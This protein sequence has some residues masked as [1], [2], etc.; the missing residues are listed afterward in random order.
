MSEPVEITV[1]FTAEDLAI[2]TRHVGRRKPKRLNAFA[3]LIVFL[4][5]ALSVGVISSPLKNLQSLLQPRSLYILAAIALVAVLYYVVRQ[6]VRRQKYGFFAKR[7]FRNRINESA[8]LRDPKSIRFSDAGVRYAD[9]L[10]TTEIV[11]EAYTEI[12]ETDDYLY[13]YTSEQSAQIFPK[14]AF[15]EHGLEM[16]RI[17]L[18]SYLPPDRNL[19]LLA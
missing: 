15:S 4:V 3:P 9:R 2:T 11:W 10:S 18:S 7:Y 8:A 14:R 12:E 13:F 16:L 17:L 19:E 5:V 1:N 6:V